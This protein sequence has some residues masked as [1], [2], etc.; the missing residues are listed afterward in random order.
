MTRTVGTIPLKCLENAINVAIMLQYGCN[1]ATN[2]PF[3]CSYHGW[4]HLVYLY[5]GCNDIVIIITHS[6]LL[7]SQLAH[8]LVQHKMA[9]FTNLLRRSHA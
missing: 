7:L 1:H 9:M 2:K 3:I 5:H 6:S 4:N 8:L